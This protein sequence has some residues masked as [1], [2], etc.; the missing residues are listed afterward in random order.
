[1]YAILNENHGSVKGFL[2]RF[3]CHEHDCLV[4]ELIA[5]DIVSLSHTSP[6]KS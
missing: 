1:M 3:S 6:F 2:I 4:G 5:S